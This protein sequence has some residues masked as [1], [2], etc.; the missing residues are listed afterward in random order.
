MNTSPIM[1][2]HVQ[3][4]SHTIVHDLQIDSSASIVTPVPRN[5]DLMRKYFLSVPL[6]VVKRLLN[7]P[8]NM[9][10]LD[11]SLNISMTLIR[12]HFQRLMSVV[13]MNVL[14]LIPF[15]QILLPSSVMLQQLKFSLELPLDLL[16]CFL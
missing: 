8:P 3:T 5:Y 6:N 12:L 13:V 10:D 2:L 4:H 1:V 9:P 11:G 7:Q 14:L 15:L 16:M